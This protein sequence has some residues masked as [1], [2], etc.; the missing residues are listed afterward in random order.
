MY[1]YRFFK[2]VFLIP[3][4]LYFLWAFLYYMKMFVISPKRIAER[5]YETLFIYFMKMKTPNRVL[6]M[7]GQ[8]LAPLFFMCFHAGFF[9]GSSILAILAYNSYIFSTLLVIAWTTNSLWNAANFYMEYFSKKY[10]TNLKML[11]QM[12]TKLKE[13]ID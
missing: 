7:F 9:I 1:D 5:N 8:S 6:Q 12:E 2:T 10:E 11:E 13:E 3:F 4:G